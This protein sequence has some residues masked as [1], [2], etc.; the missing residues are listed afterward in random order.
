MEQ[1]ELQ[2]SQSAREVLKELFNEYPE[3]ERIITNLDFIDSLDVVLW[4]CYK[5]KP[6]TISTLI[7]TLKGEIKNFFNQEKQIMI[8]EKIEPSLST[9][10]FRLNVVPENYFNT[11]FANLISTLNRK[12]N[13]N[14]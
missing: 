10:G 1:M 8:K 6:D 14:P 3:F 4:Q 7:L 2:E 12:I 5:E 13:S 11:F 9:I